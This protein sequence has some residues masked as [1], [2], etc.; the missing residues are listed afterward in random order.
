[1]KARGILQSVR[2]L[3]LTASILAG[4]VPSFVTAQSSGSPSI[5]FSNPL[6]FNCNT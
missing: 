5:R 6:N 4:G 1:M 2:L 3:F